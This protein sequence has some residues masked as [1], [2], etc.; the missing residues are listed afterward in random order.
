MSLPLLPLLLLATPSSTVPPLYTRAALRGRPGYMEVFLLSLGMQ[1]R[2]QVTDLNAA[3]YPAVA[4]MTTGYVFR[5][6]NQ[7]TVM[8]LQRI[9]R[10]GCCVTVDV[11][12][13]DGAA[14]AGQ[15]GSTSGV[16]RVAAYIPAAAIFGY[17]VL[18]AESW[19]VFVLA[20]I[21][22]ILSSRFLTIMVLRARM[23]P[24]WHGAAEP[25]VMG[26]LLV[27]LSRDRWVRMRGLVDDLKAVTSGTWL[28]D[29]A[30]GPLWL[31][32][33]DW[34]ASL[35]VYFAVVVMA[36][37][38]DTAA[39]YVLVFAALLGHVVLA[40][41]NYRTTDAVMHGRR[42][43]PVAVKRYQ[44]RLDLANEL[45]AELGRDDWAVRLGMITPDPEQRH[46][47]KKVSRTRRSRVVDEVVTM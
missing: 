8:F 12:S 24:T 11:V 47:I 1:T 25:G 3:E 35:F 42:L 34:L 15:T 44:R 32:V 27:L 10:P 31:A 22:I 23:V 29:D 5:V 20:A 13:S 19:D 41:S 14:S 17:Q 7:A 43:V 26:D 38:T 4:A 39:Q 40:W 30:D 45:I 46:T 16:P 33:S 9:G 2:L 37:T 21:V 36:N 6:E 28:Q 18:L